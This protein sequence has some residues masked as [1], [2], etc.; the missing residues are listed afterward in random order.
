MSTMNI[1][2]IAFHALTP[3][4]V[5]GEVFFT[6]STAAETAAA[7]SAFDK[8]YDKMYQGGNVNE[9]SWIY[10]IKI[11]SLIQDLALYP[12]G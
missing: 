2:R 4:H 11:P 5:P 8:W 9:A 3:D 1:R 12:H 10:Y 6:K 7:D